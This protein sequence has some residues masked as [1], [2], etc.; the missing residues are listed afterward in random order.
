MHPRD[1]VSETA[2]G[3]RSR[4]FTEMSRRRYLIDVRNIEGSD[5]WSCNMVPGTSVTAVMYQN[6]S[7]DPKHSVRVAWSLEWALSH[8]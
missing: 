5:T 7:Q 3:R 2:K 4:E 1:E 8:D 6:K